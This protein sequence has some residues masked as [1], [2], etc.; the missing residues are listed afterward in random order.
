MLELAINMGE[1]INAGTTQQACQKPP[2]W[3]VFIDGTR[4][5]LR[6]NSNKKCEWKTLR[7]IEY[8][9]LK[10][11]PQGLDVCDEHLAQL[12]ETGA[13]PRR[14]AE[15]SLSLAVLWPLPRNSS[16]RGPGSRCQFRRSVLQ[17]PRCTARSRHVRSRGKV[18]TWKKARQ[19]SGDLPIRSSRPRECRW[20]RNRCH[21][22]FEENFL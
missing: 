2:E 19:Q 3:R 18:Q 22:Q 11:Y 20:R 15:A 13:G 16:G 12:K 6:L 5:P 9:Q 17:M 14:S 10:N 21:R 1:L 7:H 8:A 4:I